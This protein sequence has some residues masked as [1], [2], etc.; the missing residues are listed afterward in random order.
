MIYY[1]FPSSINLDCIILV[2]DHTA[3]YI[4]VDTNT[5]HGDEGKVQLYKVETQTLT[6]YD[7]LFVTVWAVNKVCILKTRVR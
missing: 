4:H 6:N 1:S 5:D 2:Q 3:K 7:E